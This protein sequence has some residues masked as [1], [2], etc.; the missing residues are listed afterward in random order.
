VVAIDSPPAKRARAGSVK[1]A[2]IIVASPRWAVRQF[3]R[4]PPVVLLGEIDCANVDR[5]AATVTRHAQ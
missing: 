2:F 4:R 1:S 3:L 5:L